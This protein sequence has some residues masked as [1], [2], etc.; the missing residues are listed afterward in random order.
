M[1]PL[2][3]LHSDPPSLASQ[4]PHPGTGQPACGAPS[5]AERGS[6][7]GSV[8]GPGLAAGGEADLDLLLGGGRSEKRLHRV[9][10]GVR[11]RC[12]LLAVRP[13]PAPPT[14]LAP[15]QRP[16][17]PGLSC[18]SSPWRDK[19]AS[20][21]A[22]RP[23][24]GSAPSAPT[25]RLSELLSEPTAQAAA[26]PGGTCSN[27]AETTDRADLGVG[28]APTDK[29]GPAPPQAPGTPLKCLRTGAPGGH[30]FHRALPEQPQA[31]APR[32]LPP[33]PPHVGARIPPK[34]QA[35]GRTEDTPPQQAVRRAGWH[36]AVSLGRRGA[37]CPHPL[38]FPGGQG[39]SPVATGCPG[40]ARRDQGRCDG[41]GR[42]PA[43]RDG[44]K[45]GP[46]SLPPISLEMAPWFQNDSLP[47]LICILRVRSFALCKS[48]DRNR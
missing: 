17:E 7:W 19:R 14:Q 1:P 5:P 16:S 43:G 10:V 29:V 32:P 3:R 41:A 36:A 45:C 48:L 34:P 37:Q 30:H 11:A 24:P 12:P 13:E 25:L 18:H 21:L 9:A 22:A 39:Q 35:H 28:E 46:P 33:L 2:P 20:L 26:G 47:L 27:L 15:F 31:W 4:H 23:G 38:G 8:P 44:V 42:V 6:G 40:Q